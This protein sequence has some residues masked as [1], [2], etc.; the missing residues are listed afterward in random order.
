M[1][2]VAA[3]DVDDP[4]P[5]RQ[6]A[7]RLQDA[8]GLEPAAHR[9]DD[10]VLLGRELEGV[11]VVGI[12]ARQLGQRR[13]R[14]EVDERAVG[15]AH[16]QEGVRADVVLEVLSDADRLTIGRAADAAGGRLQVERRGAGLVLV[17]DGH[18][19]S[20]RARRR[21]FSRPYERSGWPVTR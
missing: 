21:R 11:V 12:D 18:G 5:G 3:T 4:G 7:E 2:A 10:A 16:G 13:A 19:S 20:S 9:V 8:A 1:E 6:V 15:A 17:D 14:V